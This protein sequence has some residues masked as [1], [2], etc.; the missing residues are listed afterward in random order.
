MR[1]MKKMLWILFVCLL[2]VPALAETP[3]F[4]ADE[5][6]QANARKWAEEFI[7]FAAAKYDVELD[8]SR[9]SIKYLDDIVNDLH[10]TY[11]SESPPDEQVMP[12]SRGLGS[13][14]AEVYRIFN[15][16]KWGWFFHEDGGFP[17]V[18]TTTGSELLPL[19][20]AFDRIKTG[21]DPD[22]WEYYQQMTTY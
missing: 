8:F 16:G 11:V 4:E 1:Q 13:Y 15:G 22:I 12:L 19:E 17:G 3:R 9:Q 6:L 18:E 2:P 10:A 5:I 20:K 21:A 7:Q 14:V